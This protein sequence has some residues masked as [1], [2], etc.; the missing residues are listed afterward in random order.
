MELPH[1]SE[2]VEGA[3]RMK[4]SIRYTQNKMSMFDLF[5]GVYAILLLCSGIHMITGM[6]ILH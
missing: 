6:G 1:S 2:M 4:D 5:E 3:V